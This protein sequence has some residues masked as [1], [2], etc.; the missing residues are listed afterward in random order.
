MVDYSKWK[1]IEVSDDEDDTHPNIDTASLFRWRHQAR[2]ERMQEA[3]REKQDIDTRIKI[4][5]KKKADIGD[6]KKKGEDVIDL[7]EALVKE[8]KEITKLK[9]EYEKKQR[10]TP[11]NV[12]TIGQD[13]FSKTII[14]NPPKSVKKELTEEEKAKNL[15]EFMDKNEK[16]LKEFGILRKYEDSKRFLMD[17]PE[18]ACEDTANFL[19]IWCVELAVMDKNELMNHVSHQAI[20]IQFLLELAKQLDVD[21]RSCISSFFTKIAQGGNTEYKETFEAELSLFRER[22]KNRAAEKIA[23]VE[24]EEREQRLGPGG[25][26]P[27]EVLNT[28][29]EELRTCFQTQDI[30]LLKETIRTMDEEEAKYHMK[31]CVDSGLWVPDAK[32]QAADGDADQNP[33]NEEPGQDSV[34][35][36]D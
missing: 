23:E 14:N 12:D 32:S 13:G 4:H 26:D 33:E 5:E 9:H 34:E 35:N 28:L 21:P 18:L 36:Q 8:E 3:E 20:A 15:R 10:T 11:W 30:P 29:P 19:V 17:H 7:E 25:L 22:I 31:R 24:K 1:N 2:V 27:L 6:K 16:I